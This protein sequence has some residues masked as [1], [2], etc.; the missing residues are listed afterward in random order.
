M[1]KEESLRY[2]LIIFGL[3]NIFILAFIIPL[4][5]GDILLWSPRN[6]P[7]DMMIGSINLAMGMIMLLVAQNPMRHKSFIDFII[8]S[9]V[10]HAIVM[11]VYAQNI[12]HI[13][14]AMTV[15]SIGVLPLLFYPW[16]LRDFLRYR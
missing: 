13:F 16:S 12:M 9:N 8:I 14:D 6:L 15:C 7:T 5:F 4:F 10:F 3:F 1:K 2:Y 11:F